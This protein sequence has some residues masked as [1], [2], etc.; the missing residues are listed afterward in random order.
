MKTRN[1]AELIACCVQAFENCHTCERLNPWNSAHKERAEYLTREFLPSG[2][3]FDCGTKLLLDE[4]RP[5]KLV[6]FT[7][8]HHMDSNGSY[9]GWT[10]HKVTVRP[11]LVHG[12][13]L[14]VGGRNRNDIKDY[15]Y[16]S[17]W[18]AL[19]RRAEM[20]DIR[21]EPAAETK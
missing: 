19:N 8:F 16:E 2:S 21:P 14:T 7:E 11:S 17:F 12:L 1:V 5:E 10:S 20:P 13:I 9:D 18:D 3:G 15:I 6:F 4:S